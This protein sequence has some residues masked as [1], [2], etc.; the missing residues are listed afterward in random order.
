MRC[1]VR[2]RAP[3]ITVESL[4]LLPL[5]PP[6]KCDFAKFLYKLQTARANNKQIYTRSIKLLDLALLL[7]KYRWQIDVLVENKAKEI[8]PL[9][10]DTRALLV[11]YS[12]ANI[13][14]TSR[15]YVKNYQ[16][17]LRILRKEFY[18]TVTLTAAYIG[19]LSS[20]SLTRRSQN[21]D[22]FYSSY[23]SV[24]EPCIQGFNLNITILPKGWIKIALLSQD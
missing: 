10:T 7:S 17:Y 3:V 2:N 1:L 22:N 4:F 18:L 15:T 20:L 9:K 6:K 11:I 19:A 12:I 5:T 8:I 16:Q 14:E 21:C 23:K 24:R 13:I